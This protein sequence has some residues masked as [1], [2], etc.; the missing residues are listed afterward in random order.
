MTRVMVRKRMTISYPAASGADLADLLNR[1]KTS[2]DSPY[3]NRSLSDI[4]G[5]ILADAA[6]REVETYCDGH[7]RRRPRESNSRG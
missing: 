3:W 1:L 6:Q 5:M 4:G 2:K 7:R